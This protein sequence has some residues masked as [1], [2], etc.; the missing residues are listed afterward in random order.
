MLSRIFF[1]H[2]KINANQCIRIVTSVKGWEIHVYKSDVLNS[3]DN[4][5]TIFRKTGSITVVNP[6]EVVVLCTMKKGDRFL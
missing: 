6:E 2:S 1:L 5:L 4:M 3:D